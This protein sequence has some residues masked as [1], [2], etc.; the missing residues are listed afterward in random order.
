M[1]YKLFRPLKHREDWPAAIQ[2]LLGPFLMIAPFVLQAT[3]DLSIW[4]YVAYWPLFWFGISRNNYILHNH[5]HNP[6]SRHKGLNRLLDYALGMVTGM[7]AGTWRLTHNHGH[8]VTYMR[9]KLP[10]HWIPFV[11]EDEPLLRDYSLKNAFWFSAKT[12]PVQW[13]GILNI[14][15]VRWMDGGFR[16]PYYRY[17]F[18][19]AVGIWGL[20]GLLAWVDWQ[21]CLAFV[22]LPHFLAHFFSR[23]IDY[24]FHVCA[25][26]LVNY[27]YCFSCINDTYNWWCWNAGYHL[28]HHDQPRLHWSLL[29]SH[30]E[31]LSTKHPKIKKLTRTYNYSGI[32]ALHHAHWEQL[33][34]RP[35]MF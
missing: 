31:S 23:Y 33:D 35:R 1:S 9:D 10:H 8:H 16:A 2:A 20:V 28:A 7:S 11:E 17:L 34:P 3:Y 19:E 15:L 27:E 24:L 13:F 32:F 12:T 18:W 30:H 4:F 22:L 25:N 6:M 29:P 26:P 5:C 21:F 14:S